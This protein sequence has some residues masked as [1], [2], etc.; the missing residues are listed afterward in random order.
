[1]TPSF[2]SHSQDQLKEIAQD[3]LRFAKDKGASD[4]AVEISE[5]QGL[6]VTVRKGQ[7]ETIEQNK[8]KVVIVPFAVATR[9]PRIFPHSRS[10]TRLKLPITL[11]ASPPKMIVLACLKQ[12][13]WRCSRVTSS[14][15][16]P[17]H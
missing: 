9:A 2:F 8:D 5:G 13:F 4:A 7:I 6:S 17:G 3:V 12:N 10:K 14:F 1:M 16:I 15:F 11:R